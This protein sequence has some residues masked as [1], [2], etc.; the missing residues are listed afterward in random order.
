MGDETWVNDNTRNHKTSLAW[1]HLSSTPTRNFKAMPT[2][3]KVLC[4]LSFATKDLRDHGGAVST[5]GCC[6]TLERVQQAFHCRRLG[7]LCHSIIILHSNGRH[8]SANWPCEWL[9]N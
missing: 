8:H 6:G 4:P 9:W 3:R 1:K 2:V 5:E 7:L